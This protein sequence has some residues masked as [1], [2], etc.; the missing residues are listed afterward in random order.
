MSHNH[1]CSNEHDHDHDHDH[2]HGHESSVGQ[3]D[4][5]YQY[6]DH[7]NVR[8]LNATDDSNASKILKPW[9]KR[10][11]ETL[12]AESDAD[13][14][15]II[16][17]PFTGSVK[18]RSILIKSGPGN[19]TPSK[20]L[21]FANHDHLDFVDVANIQPVQE[22]SIVQS[23]EIGDY[24][25]NWLNFTQRPAK[26]SNISS[27]T[28]FFPSSQGADTTRLYYLNRK[29][30]PTAIVYE[31]QANPADHPK[32]QGTESFGTHIGLGGG[33]RSGGAY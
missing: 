1:S 29:E 8:I 22:F 2:D 17:I 25:V 7:S 16:R 12:Y 5:L 3:S 10:L 30:A 20:V 4:N 31:A 6:I 11:D 32:I 26:F 9:D 23:R 21:L 13:D 24:A 28:L 14:Q 33:G 19:Q 15:L 18:L 27:I